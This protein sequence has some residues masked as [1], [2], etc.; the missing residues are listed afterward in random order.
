MGDKCVVCGEADQGKPLYKKLGSGEYNVEVIVAL[1]D[2]ELTSLPE[3]AK[4]DHYICWDCDETILQEY[5]RYLEYEEK[6]KVQEEK[7]KEEKRIR[8]NEQQRKRRM[9]VSEKS[10]KP[11]HPVKTVPEDIYIPKLKP[12]EVQKTNDHQKSTHCVICDCTFE[13]A[14]RGYYRHTLKKM[15]NDDMDVASVM[16]FLGLARR[17]APEVKAKRFVCNKCFYTIRRNYKNKLAKGTSI[18][19]PSDGKASK[20]KQP[21]HRA[22]PDEH[23]AEIAKLLP[24]ALAE[25]YKI[26]TSDTVCSASVDVDVRGTVDANNRI[27]VNR[28]DAEVEEEE[29]L[30][31]SQDEHGNFVVDM[32]IESPSKDSNKMNINNSEQGSKVTESHRKKKNVMLP[33]RHH[34][35]LLENDGEKS[36]QAESALPGEISLQVSAD[37]K[38]IENVDSCEDMNSRTCNICGR[39]FTGKPD[40]WWHTLS[41]SLT[42]LE[43]V[44]V[45][46][47]LQMLETSLANTSEKAR[48]A[49]QVCNLCFGMVSSGFRRQVVERIA[50]QKNID[51]SQVNFSKIKVRMMRKEDLCGVDA[52]NIRKNGLDK[53]N[54]KTASSNDSNTSKLLVKGKNDLHHA[55][56]QK[57]QK[58]NNIGAEKIRD[59]IPGPRSSTKKKHGKYSTIKTNNKY[60]KTFDSSSS[61][62]FSY[63]SNNLSYE[64]G[65]GAA[66]HVTPK[67]GVSSESNIDGKRKKPV[68]NHKVPSAAQSVRTKGNFNHPQSEKK[69]NLLTSSDSKKGIVSSES[70]KEIPAICS[71]KEVL[72][73]NRGVSQFGGVDGDGP[74]AVLPVNEKKYYE[75]NR[76]CQFYFPLSKMQESKV[77]LS[78]MRRS[79]PK[80]AFDGRTLLVHNQPNGGYKISCSNESPPSSAFQ[81]LLNAVLPPNWSNCAKKVKE[82]KT[83]KENEGIVSGRCVV[84]AYFFHRPLSMWHNLREDIKPPSLQVPVRW[85]LASLSIAPVRLTAKEKEEG[86]VCEGCFSN[87]TKQFEEFVRVK[88]GE[89]C[90]MIPSQVVITDY[91]VTFNQETMNIEADPVDLTPEEEVEESSRIVSKVDSMLK[92]VNFDSL[93]DGSYI[94]PLSKEDFTT[95]LLLALNE[96]RVQIGVSSTELMDW[97]LQ[98]MP[99]EYHMKGLQ[100]VESK[101][102][103]FINS[104]TSALDGSSRDFFDK[105]STTLPVYLFTP[106][107]S[108]K[109]LK[110]TAECP[111]I[112]KEIKEEV[113]EVQSDRSERE[114]KWEDF[115]NRVN[116]DHLLEGKG[117]PLPRKYFNNGLLYGLWRLAADLKVGEDVLGNWLQQV[118][119]IPLE[120]EHVA[121]LLKAPKPIHDHLLQHPEDIR[122]LDCV[123]IPEPPASSSNKGKGVSKLSGEKEDSKTVNPDSETIPAGENG[124]LISHQASV[125]SSKGVTSKRKAEWSTQEKN[126]NKR[127]R[128]VTD[129]SASSST[130]ASVSTPAPSKRRG[131]KEV[132]TSMT[133]STAKL[134]P[135]D[136]TPGNLKSNSEIS[137]SSPKV[138]ISISES[139]TSKSQQGSVTKAGS[140]ISQKLTLTRRRLKK[141]RKVRRF[142]TE[143]SQESNNNESHNSIK[144]CQEPV[145]TQESIQNE[146]KDSAGE[147]G[148]GELASKIKELEEQLQAVKRQNQELLELNEKLGLGASKGKQKEIQVKKNE[149]ISPCKISTLKSTSQSKVQMELTAMKPSQDISSPGNTAKRQVKLSLKRGSLS[150]LKEGSEEVHP[151][152]L[153][154]DEVDQASLMKVNK[155]KTNNKGIVQKHLVQSECSQPPVTSSGVPLPVGID[156]KICGNSESPSPEETGMANVIGGE[157]CLEKDGKSEETWA[158]A[159]GKEDETDLEKPEENEDIKDM[160]EKVEMECEGS[161]KKQTSIKDRVDCVESANGR[162][163]SDAAQT[164]LLESVKIKQVPSP[165]T[166]ASDS[167]DI[168]HSKLTLDNEVDLRSE[169]V[170]SEIR[171]ESDLR[172]NI[173]LQNEQ[174]GNS[175][176]SDM[177]TEGEKD[178]SNS[179][180]RDESP[181]NSKT[182]EGCTEVEYEDPTLQE[183]SRGVLDSVMACDNKIQSH[184][185]GSDPSCLEKPS[186][187]DDRSNQYSDKGEGTSFVTKSSDVQDPNDLHVDEPEFPNTLPEMGEQDADSKF[188]SPQE[189]KVQMEGKKLSEN[190]K[191]NDKIED[192]AEEEG[193]LS[194]K[195]RHN[196]EDIVGKIH[197]GKTPDLERKQI[198]VVE[199]GENEQTH[200]EG[201]AKCFEKGRKSDTEEEKTETKE[202]VSDKSVC[203][204]NEESLSDSI[205]KA[206]EPS[207]SSVTSGKKGNCLGVD[208]NKVIRGNLGCTETNKKSI[209]FPT[210][211]G[212]VGEASSSKCAVREKVSGT[213]SKKI[214]VK[215]ETLVGQFTAVNKHNLLSAKKRKA[216]ECKT[217]GTDNKGKQRRVDILTPSSSTQSSSTGTSPDKGAASKKAKPRF[218]DLMTYDI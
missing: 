67:H 112:K 174:E 83:K 143:E 214:K 187:E 101:V 181:G 111:E 124:R 148:S 162:E 41:S 123:I 96:F 59:S 126:Y 195:K 100:P 74:D 84:C 152:V 88:I 107:K 217:T 34:R 210:R 205:L 108:M 58:V 194:I 127:L 172:N 48:L 116:I 144:E 71:V 93:L 1:R 14:N 85:V 39:T 147:S 146:A 136:Q 170:A 153:S 182:S 106:H 37:G 173:T 177:I 57:K 75:V 132:D 163:G 26:M 45:S 193:S 119:P 35:H 8:K 20:K 15:V 196:K 161:A 167:S 150:S 142:T 158:N 157:K 200:V 155:L 40:T 9:L 52:Q 207:D 78:D 117:R 90:D 208:G 151:H 199:S 5:G 166:V 121:L 23:A 188:V 178:I 110:K 22:T 98:L 42:G 131:S 197:K 49:C 53:D 6:R 186:L 102:F 202:D 19:S 62:D 103:M 139:P 68:V 159:R 81:F 18:E 51:A 137:V 21:I 92:C 215:R 154:T 4:A 31:I 12:V 7:N 38:K 192:I 135:D 79:L 89:S 175:S 211:I 165:S 56:E 54:H 3:S 120:K 169:S 86:K 60:G 32:K 185:T 36:S 50:R 141:K 118:S 204:L 164:S 61:D 17:I 115:L 24:P 201:E 65:L 13:V 72:V 156:K 168:S 16:E 44:T 129:P 206:S 64:R 91:V 113:P 55:N 105:I 134:K 133:V 95:C 47:A 66:E 122:K 213:Q 191:G 43:S 176:S 46:M 80:E 73:V 29:G 2:L 33:K 104:I 145:Q 69:Q 184:H 82:I 114:L 10:T 30:R 130:P 189:D 180:R 70:R 212:I 209:E 109:A 77:V 171:K 27:E 128:G 203:P 97:L 190:H 216:G 11:K 25:C 87:L 183:S 179:E 125:M 94:N 149:Q 28:V 63:D 140:G 198:S 138:D 99:M 76:N 160:E 218:E